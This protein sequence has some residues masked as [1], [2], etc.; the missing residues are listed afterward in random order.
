MPEARPGP[1]RVRR[2][3]LIH[4][5]HTDV[6]YTAP[7]GVV[8][9][10][11]SDWLRAAIS[12][13]ESRPAFRWT[14]E[15]FWGVER[16]L[17]RADAAWRDRFVKQVRA[18]RIGLSASW[19]NL[20]ELPDQ[21]L[22]DEL[23][24][25]A[26]RWAATQ[27]LTVSCA[28][29][30][31]I[32]GHSWGTATALLDQGVR[33]LFTCIHSHHGLPPLF[34]RHQPFWWE[35]PDGRR[36]LV[37]NG[38]HYH[39]GNELGLAPGALSSYLIKDECRAEEI[40]GDAWPV[41]LRR[42]PRYLEALEAA[43]HPLAFAPLMISG[44]RTDNSPPSAAVLEQV[45]RWAREG[46]PAIAIRLATLEEVLA[47]LEAARGDWPVHRGDWPDW[48]SDGAASRPAAVR[49]F[50]Q[51][52]RER[53][54]CRQLA[55]RAA[56]PAPELDRQ[57]AWEEEL[58][59]RLGLFAEHTFSHAA[60]LSQPWH[61]GVQRIAAAKEAQA[62][63]ALDACAR[64]VAELRQLL[65]E[66]LPAP[67]L[68]PRWRVENLGGEPWA[69]PVLLPVQWHELHELG[70][71]RPQ[72]L[73]DATGA[74]RPC[75]RVPEG[76]LSWVRL[77][78]REGLELRLR[79]A[80]PE[81][82][83]SLRPDGGWPADGVADLAAHAAAP[84][85][86]GRENVLA[87]AWGRL[88][89][90]PPQGVVSLLDEEGRSLIE[91]RDPRPPFTLVHELTPCRLPEEACA[92]RAVMGRNR[93]GEAVER[94]ESRWRRL[95]RRESGAVCEELEVE[96]AAPGCPWA[97]LLLRLHHS[98]PRL[99]VELR[100]HKESRW[101]AENLFLSLPRPAGVLWVDKAG[102][103]LRPGIDQL[104]GT[105]LDYTSVQAGYALVAEG[106]G[107]AVAMPDQHLLQMG[108]L[109]HG[110]RRLAEPPAPPAGPLFAWL[111]T[112]YWETNFAA[113]LGGFHAFRFSLHWGR[114]CA[115]A[116]SALVVARQAWEDMLVLRTGDTQGGDA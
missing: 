51:A 36:L 110:P 93:K 54:F 97:V 82:P 63:L 39:L 105:L 27:G 31:D 1:R 53:R 76:F 50:R 40:F 67:G 35:A 6:G 91:E 58:E 108:P 74:E 57:Q 30:A 26:A 59:T 111:M 106:R 29:S 37:Y 15:G 89:W 81:P 83:G 98:H 62:A 69:G 16:F 71:D 107:L 3:L 103:P 55:D 5:T 100:L 115:D 116:A 113:E 46:D 25:R 43:G 22:L 21:T 90:R 85:W 61:T 52:L 56:L 112:N 2:I 32:N 19:L 101:E 72:G 87:T 23:C 99:D 17:E 44:L 68:A 66:A 41:A 94:A 4:H 60:S 38:E 49:Q 86:Q 28:M 45:E 42:I 109:A 95:L 79:P 10:W 13:A 7:P 24:G 73:E 70:L 96:L 33:L 64:R 114:A 104:P 48:W 14:C 9:A 77:A 11:Q 102:G 47:E 65:G 92:S 84:T 34:R 78:P 8:A 12:L 80:P 18:G 88:D 20:T 75:Q